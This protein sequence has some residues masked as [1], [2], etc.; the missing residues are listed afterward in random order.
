MNM[1]TNK[2]NFKLALAVLKSV[3]KDKDHRP[4]RV[5]VDFERQDEETV[6]RSLGRKW[7]TAIE[8]LNRL[9]CH[10]EQLNITENGACTEI[11]LSTS[12]ALEK[13]VGCSRSGVSR[14]LEKAV[15][16]GML[17][18]TDITYSIGQFGKGYIYNPEV[19]HIVMGMY[20]KSAG[21]A[22]VEDYKTIEHGDCCKPDETF[23]S[24]LQFGAVRG[25]KRL[26]TDAQVVQAVHN[27]YPWLSEYQQ[28][29]ERLNERLGNSLLK[30]R[31][32]P[33]VKRNDKNEVSK[34]GIRCTS[35]FCNTESSV[36]SGVLDKLL[37][38]WHEYDVPNSIYR[39]NRFMRMGE[40]LDDSVDLYTTMQP[41][42]MATDREMFKKSA[43]MLYFN[44]SGAVIVRLVNGKLRRKGLRTAEGKVKAI[45]ENSFDACQSS[46]ESV[47]GKR[48]GSEIFLHESCIYIDTLECLLD[49][50]F[51]VAQCYDCF[52]TD[53]DATEFIRKNLPKVAAKY[54]NKVMGI[55]ET[56]TKDEVVDA[57][58]LVSTLNSEETPKRTE[59]VDR[60]A[61]DEEEF[62]KNFDDL[63]LEG[64]DEGG[65]EE[66]EEE[67]AE[68]VDKGSVPPSNEV[69]DAEV[70]AFFG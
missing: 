26:L 63:G 45:L 49:A 16:I 30:M 55:E 25:E 39:V 15:E 51:K 48:Y 60:V 4:V 27:Q 37:G 6:V 34:V 35:M 40:W 10:L 56:E 43:M 54:R 29:V 33:S 58:E 32:C 1:K 57:E 20:R 24:R 3:N 9:A 28:K 66:V 31:F 50:G 47:I 13:V 21:N 41:Q 23:Q 52:Y 69:L 17:R 53:K 18:C 5:V 38:E 67:S 46:M 59:W 36:R 65:S 44:A 11:R 64:A 70:L 68:E 2:D 12:G 42:D 19:G 62:N 8:S 22:A 7:K 14:L 61:L